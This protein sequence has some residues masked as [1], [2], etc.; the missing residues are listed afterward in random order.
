MKTL[1]QTLVALLFVLATAPA[2]AQ[3]APTC[4]DFRCQ[5][6][7]QVEQECPCDARTNHGQY[8]SCV[9]H[10][11]SGLTDQGLPT[12]CKG[13][14]TR[15]AARSICGKSKQGFATCTT[16]TYG[17]CVSNDPDPSTCDN[18]PAVQCST[19]TDCVVS[20]RCK[21]TRNTQACEAA[22]GVVNLTPTCCSSCNTAP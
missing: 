21:F 22:G 7:A 9:A 6:Q 15:C 1:G 20:T 14:I 5:F 17:T 19:N 3:E 8:V 12:S 10:V 16:F 18:D 4:E 13:K 11:V 2:R